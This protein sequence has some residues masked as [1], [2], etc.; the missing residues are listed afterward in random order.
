MELKSSGVLLGWIPCPDPETAERLGRMAVEK[1]LAACANILPGMT[2]LYH[3]EGKLQR[4]PEAL[5]VLKTTETARTS[6]IELLVRAHP[7]DLPAISFVAVA[8]GHPPFLDWV[9]TET[10]PEP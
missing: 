9:A 2:S 4:E 10:E 3:W 8:G 6:L 7:Y 1:R 5:L